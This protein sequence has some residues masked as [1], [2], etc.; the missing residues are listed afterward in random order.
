M[1]PVIDDNRIKRKKLPYLYRLGRYISKCV[2]YY[3]LYPIDYSKSV[4]NSELQ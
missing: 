2:W 1:N 3:V 4:K